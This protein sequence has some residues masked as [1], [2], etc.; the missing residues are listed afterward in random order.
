ME[1]A[2]I[3]D[4][5]ATGFSHS[6]SPGHEIEVFSPSHKPT[7]IERKTNISPPSYFGKVWQDNTLSIHNLCCGHLLH[8]SQL[9]AIL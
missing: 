3:D 2:G 8:E 6:Y 7:K 4:E 5:G 1:D 9:V